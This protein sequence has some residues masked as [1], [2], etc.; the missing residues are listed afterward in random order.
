MDVVLFV[1][2]TRSYQYCTEQI[3]KEIEMSGG[4]L[5]YEEIRRV[6]R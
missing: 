1:T 4:V 3:W 2:V 5:C 6:R